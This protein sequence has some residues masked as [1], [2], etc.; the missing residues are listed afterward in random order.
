[1][2]ADDL[3]GDGKAE[4]TT[5]VGLGAGPHV[6]R[7]DGQTGAELSSFFAFS[8]TFLGGVNV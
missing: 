8:P 5:G 3:N 6:K 7:F 2:G 4:I 1:M